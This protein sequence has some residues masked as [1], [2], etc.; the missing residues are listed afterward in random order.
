VKLFLLSFRFFIWVASLGSTALL[1]WA[2]LGVLEG[3]GKFNASL[4]ANICLFDEAS[5]DF[6][7]VTIEFSEPFLCILFA[8]ARYNVNILK[9]TYPRLLMSTI[10]HTQFI[11]LFV[12]C[13][14]YNWRCMCVHAFAYSAR[15][16]KPICTKLGTFI[17]WL[18]EEDIERPKLRKD[19]WSLSPCESSSVPC[20]LSATEEWR[21]DWSCV[22]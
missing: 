15:T 16:D 9:V 7:F 18:Q 2:Y 11:C 8:S 12:S 3:Q 4:L 14:I 13:L 21:Q 22:C 17:P 1:A 5:V 10:L 19:V 6:K 20:K